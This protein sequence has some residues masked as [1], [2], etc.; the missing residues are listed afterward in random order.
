MA[1]ARM[2]RL[3]ASGRSIWLEEAKRAVLGGIAT[4]PVGGGSARYKSSFLRSRVPC[5]T[6]AT[7]TLGCLGA[8]SS[9]GRT[10][11]PCLFARSWQFRMM[12]GRRRIRGV[13][14]KRLPLAG[15]GRERS[16]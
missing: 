7:N 14:K 15:G 3:M 8:W 2:Q 10:S 1:T 9:T 12:E 11:A 6:Q 13:P 4:L 5:H 16:R